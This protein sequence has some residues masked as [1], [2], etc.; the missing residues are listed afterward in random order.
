MKHLRAYL[1]HSR[2]TSKSRLE[3]CLEK[4]DLIHLIESKKRQIPDENYVFVE[5]PNID[6]NQERRNASNYQEVQEPVISE[7]EQVN[8]NEFSIKNKINIFS[9]FTIVRS[10]RYSLSLKDG[11][12]DAELEKYYCLF[13]GAL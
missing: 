11:F 6:V 7:N 10:V 1:I 13:Y 4:Q 3:S 12:I 8:E 9:L 2:I 5:R